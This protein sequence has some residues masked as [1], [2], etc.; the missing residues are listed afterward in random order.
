MFVLIG[1]HFYPGHPMKVPY[2]LHVEMKGT[3]SSSKGHLLKGKLSLLTLLDALKFRDS[4]R[5]YSFYKLAF[6]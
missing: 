5:N 6:F 4:V 1:V 3:V 2:K